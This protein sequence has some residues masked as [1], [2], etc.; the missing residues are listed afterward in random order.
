MINTLKVLKEKLDNKQN[1]L[2][3]VNREMES[4]ITNRTKTLEIKNE[5]RDKECL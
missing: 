5:I 3:N 1:Q 4:T 2:G